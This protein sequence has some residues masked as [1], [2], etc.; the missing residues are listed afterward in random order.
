MK[1]VVI[2]VSGCGVLVYFFSYNFFGGEI[3]IQLSFIENTIMTLESYPLPHVQS[4][5]RTRTR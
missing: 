4:K 5:N 3:Y 1:E 2:I